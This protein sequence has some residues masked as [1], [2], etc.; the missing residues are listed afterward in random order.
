MAII[1]IDGVKFYKIEHKFSK[2]E[3][4]LKDMTFITQSSLP[5]INM[6]GFREYYEER[7]VYVTVN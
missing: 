6:K 1:L 2:L 3:Y 5:V 7:L 4:Q